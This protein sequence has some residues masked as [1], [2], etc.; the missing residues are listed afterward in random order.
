MQVKEVLLFHRPGD[1]SPL[2]NLDTLKIRLAFKSGL[3]AVLL[4]ATAVAQNAK[5]FPGATP[6]QRT[7]RTQERV[8]ELYIE[9][10]YDRALLIYRNELAP[11]GDKYAQYM[12]GYMHL[13]AQGTS[14][15]KAEALAWYRLAAER[16]ESVLLRA[17]DELIKTMTPGE[18]A[19]SEQIFADLWNSIGDTRLVMELIRRDMN[20]LKARTG[21]R[22]PGSA[23]SAAETIYRASGEIEGPN[24]YRNVRMRLEARLEYLESRVEVTDFALQSGYDDVRMLEQEVKQ[25]LAALGLR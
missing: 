23:S 3:L 4:C 7:L 5:P 15:D 18:I 11:L 17:R 20:T 10:A 21:S 14:A 1:L 2:R 16:G 25:E 8:E 13:Q 6:D 19:R 22:I 24:F 9:G 12:V